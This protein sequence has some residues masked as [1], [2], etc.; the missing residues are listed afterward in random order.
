MNDKNKLAC[1]VNPKTTTLQ[2]S[3]NEVREGRY[4]KFLLWFV[5]GMG[6]VE[7][8]CIFL[9]W[10]FFVR[11]KN[12]LDARVYNNISIIGFRKFSYSE[13]KKATK[14]FNQEIGRGVGGVVYKGVLLD[15]RVIAM[16][17]LAEANQG[18]EQFLAEVSSIGSLNHMNLIEL[19]GYCAEGKHRMLV[20]EFMENGSLAEHL[21]SNGLN[22]SKRFDIAL[23]TAKAWRSSHN[24][25]KAVHSLGGIGGTIITHEQVGKTFW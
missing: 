2:R 15:E 1:N 22:W 19:W 18:E 5:G 24:I 13:L 9:L 8:L 6:G 20:Y 11:S 14:N 17:K 12:N 3:F 16:K 10:F 4:I 25:F 23:G 21:R 7:I